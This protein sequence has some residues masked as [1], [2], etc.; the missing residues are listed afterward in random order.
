MV[1]TLLCNTT[2]RDLYSV[3]RAK[4]KREEED[5]LLNPAK[6]I[7]LDAVIDTTSGSSGS[8]GSVD[9]GARSLS[10]PERATFADN[11]NNELETYRYHLLDGSSSVAL[12]QNKLCEMWGIPKMTKQY[13]IVDLDKH[14][15]IEVKVSHNKDADFHVYQLERDRAEH[16]SFVHFT[17][18]GREYFAYGVAERLPGVSKAVSI[19]IESK[20]P[21]GACSRIH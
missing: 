10:L 3:F 9:V 2:P 8:S 15:F 12:T 4:R 19:L 17:P 16:T 7:R 20:I 5:A 14:I 13:D 21:H 6:R 1:C 11:T 18:H